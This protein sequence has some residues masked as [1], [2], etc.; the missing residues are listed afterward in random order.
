MWGFPVGI[1]CFL[2]FFLFW[3]SVVF[4]FLGFPGF[5]WFCTPPTN[6]EKHSEK[7]KKGKKKQR[8]LTPAKTG[9]ETSLPP[10]VLSPE[11]YPHRVRHMGSEKREKKTEN[12]R[13]E[14]KGRSRTHGELVLVHD[15]VVVLQV[16]VG[17][18]HLR[19]AQHM[20]VLDLLFSYNHNA[21]EVRKLF[22]QTS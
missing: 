8:R 13:R 16:L 18:R 15:G 6:K 4:C 7:P 10:Q 14:G 2:C 12:K 3:G 19:T 11:T 22:Y 5:S 21:H 17:V 20:H 9:L 1:I